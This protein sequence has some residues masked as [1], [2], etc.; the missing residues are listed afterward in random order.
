[1]SKIGKSIIYCGRSKILCAGSHEDE[2]GVELLNLDIS[3]GTRWQV[4]PAPRV[5]E[6][7]PAL[8]SVTNHWHCAWRVITST[9]AHGE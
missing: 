1:M 9:A 4:P 3:P 7:F 8:L 2:E 5:S 6:N